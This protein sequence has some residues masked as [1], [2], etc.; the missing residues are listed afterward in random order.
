MYRVAGHRR[1][2]GKLFG[3]FVP[4]DCLVHC[5][6]S[7]QFIDAPFLLPPGVIVL[8]SAFGSPGSSLPRLSQSLDWR[9]DAPLVPKAGV[10]R[11]GGRALVDRRAAGTRASSLLAAKSWPSAGGIRTWVGF[12]DDRLYKQARAIAGCGACWGGATIF[13]TW[14]KSTTLGSSYFAIHI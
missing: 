1:A 3:L 7:N 5:V 11:G 2:A 12:V 9:T 14:S 8:A 4:H 10:G 6:V 13:G